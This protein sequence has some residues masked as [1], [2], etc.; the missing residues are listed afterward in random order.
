MEFYTVE[1]WSK[2]KE[3]YV[4]VA[5]FKTRKEAEAKSKEVKGSRIGQGWK[6]TFAP[7]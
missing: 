4:E 2:D 3:R 7:F 6:P 5:R 1:V